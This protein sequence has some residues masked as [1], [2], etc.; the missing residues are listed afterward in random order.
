MIRASIPKGEYNCRY[1]LSALHTFAF[2]IHPQVMVLPISENP[3][4]LVRPEI[5]HS[6]CIAL[7]NADVRYQR[8]NFLHIKIK[9]SPAK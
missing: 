6:T 2:K 7:S 9:S 3:G 5:T 1:N 4:G 8:F